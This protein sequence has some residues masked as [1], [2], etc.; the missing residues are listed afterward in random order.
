MRPLLVVSSAVLTAAVSCAPCPTPPPPGCST[1]GSGTINVTSTGLPAGVAADITLTGPSAQTVTASRSLTGMGTGAWSAT[2]ERVTVADP[3]VR[4]V[5]LPTV[6]P[7]SFCLTDAATQEVTV[8]WTKVAT[9]NALWALNANATG[10]F[11]GFRSSQLASTSTQAASVVTRGGF[12]ADVAFDKDGNVWVGGADAAVSRFP[13][14]AFAMSGMATPDRELN[15]TGSAC[16]PLVGALAFDRE[17]NLYVASPCR[18]AVLRLDASQLAASGDVTPALTITVPDPGGVAFDAAGGLWVASKMDQRAWRFDASQ[19][20]A[21]SVA[22][23]TAKLGVRASAN[24][25]DTS[26]YT[27]SWLAFDTRGDLWANDF[28]ANV[29]YRV[30]AASLAATADLQPQ[31]RITLGVTALLEGFAFDGQ[32]GLWSA[33]SMGTFVRLAPAQ[34]DTSSGPGMPTLPSVTIT[35]GDVGSASNLGFYPAPAGL[36]LY[37]SLP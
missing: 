32:G 34:L 29:F 7:A 19:L 9:S 27:P 1:G 11:L 31:V 20:A 22:A 12:R 37:H 17:G 16:V 24:P 25:M 35:S 23:P 4:T 8:T 21:G 18:G 28:G 13:S 2:A 6:S 33:G 26:L 10:Q 30:G 36:P 14:S 3:L 15:L 5:Y